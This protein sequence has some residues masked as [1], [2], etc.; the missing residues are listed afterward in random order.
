MV[1]EG[2][3]VWLVGWRWLRV[4][5]KGDAFFTIFHEQIVFLTMSYDITP[6]IFARIAYA[7]MHDMT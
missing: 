6:D 5:S 2:G 3:M 7:C 4:S 1:W